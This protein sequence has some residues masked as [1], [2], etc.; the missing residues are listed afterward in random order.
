M[1]EP[2]DFEKL[3]QLVY[4]VLSTPK[5]YR[6]LK[7][8]NIEDLEMN[9]IINEKMLETLGFSNVTSVMNGLDAYHEIKNNEYDII[10]L[11]MK[12]PIKG[13]LE[14]LDDLLKDNIKIPYTIVITAYVTDEIKQ[15][16]NYRHVNDILYKP[17]DIEDLQLSLKRAQHYLFV[18]GN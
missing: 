10:L 3:K 2:Y 18:D 6:D 15:E 7:I 5:I 9:K 1:K 11:D 16:C 17:I 13:G 4:E 8:L 14:M 12:M